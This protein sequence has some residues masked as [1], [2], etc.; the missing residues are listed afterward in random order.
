MHDPTVSYATNF[1]VPQ[2]RTP[3]EHEAY[4]QFLCASLSAGGTDCDVTQRALSAFE[5]WRRAA[6]KKA[7]VSDTLPKER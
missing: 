2:C 4:R 6:P 7:A 5:H 3:E 1:P